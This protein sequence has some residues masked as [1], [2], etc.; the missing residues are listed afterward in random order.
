LRWIPILALALAV[1]CVV[2]PITGRRSIQLMSDA[3]MNELGLQAFQE[4]K[5]ESKIA[6]DPA[7][8]AIVRRVGERIARAVDEQLVHD[9]KEPF[10]WEFTVIESEQVNA[11][12]LPGGKVAFYTGILPICADETGI[13]VVMGHEIGHAYA[14]HGN[15]RVSMGVIKE[16]GLG[17]VQA[18]MSV[19]EASEIKSKALA[20]LG[21]GAQLGELKFGRDDES[22]ADRLGLLF[23]ARA[24]YDP[25]AAAPFWQRMSALGGSQSLEILSTHP[26]NETR[27]ADIETHLPAALAEYEKKQP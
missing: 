5:K 24:G 19:G 23:M 16:Y 14:G 12:C 15:N 18:A 27:I 13:A 26:A 9:G 10:Q 2:D 3:Q 1:S 21:V 4:V 22:H 8:I 11:F 25:R 6:S 20:A 17:A 7:Q